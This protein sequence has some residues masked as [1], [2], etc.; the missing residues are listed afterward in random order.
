MG[1]RGMWA[2]LFSLAVCALVGSACAGEAAKKEPASGPR[3][4]VVAKVDDVEITR[5]QLDEARRQLLLRNPQA[6]PSNVELLEEFITHILWSRHY[7]QKN[8]RPTA[9]ELRQAVAQFEAQQLRPRGIT[10]QQYLQSRNMRP[11]DYL[12]ILGVDMARQKLINSIAEKIKPEEIQAEFDAHPEW[13]DG[14]RVRISQIFV[15]T[16]ELVN[17][18]KE[19][20]KAKERI[21]QLHRQ[22]V[23]GK[24]FDLLARDYTEGPGSG[25][26]GD[27][28]WVVRKGADVDEP[29]LA[30][31]RPLKVGEITAPIQGARGW[32]ILKVSDREPA[33]LTFHGAKPRVTNELVRRRMEAL[34]EELRKAAKI[35][36]YL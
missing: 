4:D 11:E 28:G 1:R 10:Y 21:E 15:N 25:V 20:E 36:K 24:D 30:A 5:A 17:N 19:L 35:E 12:G 31:A 23:E 33:Y 7:E 29:L 13:Y 18:P 27:R 8:L 14:S 16:S 6:N 34:L 3:G 32:H 22:V 26:S 9:N 2:A